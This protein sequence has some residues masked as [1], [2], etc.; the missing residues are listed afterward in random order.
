[1]QFSLPSVYELCPNE[2]LPWPLK[3]SK[4]HWECSEAKKDKTWQI[5]FGT[6]F[7]YITHKYSYSKII[8][9]DGDSDGSKTNEGVGMP[10]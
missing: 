2:V 9:T 6:A 4:C 7:N 10:L 8:Y 5:V 3:K 1:M